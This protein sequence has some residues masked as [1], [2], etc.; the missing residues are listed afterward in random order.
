MQNDIFRGTLVRLTNEE[1]E[2]HA[3]NW[4]RWWQD[5]EYG[6]LLDLDAPQ[7]RSSKIVKK[8]IERDY[9]KDPPHEFLFGIRTLEDDRLIGFVDIGGISANGDGFVGIGL[10]ERDYWGKGYGTDA[11]QLLLRFSFTELNMHRVSL[12]VFEYN[13]RGMKSYEKAGFRHEGRAR[14]SILRDGKF[15]D[16]LFMGVMQRDW[17]KANGYA[18]G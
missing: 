17:L 11:M 4:S 13:L 5:S 7:L 1:P 2:V 8:W 16:M 10:G 18:T 9:E 6:R 3:E 12:T 14:E 15:Y